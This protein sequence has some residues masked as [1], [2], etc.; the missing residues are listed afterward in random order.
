MTNPHE[1]GLEKFIAESKSESGERRDDLAQAVL[2]AHDYVQG[3]YFVSHPNFDLGICGSVND[4]ILMGLANSILKR[5]L[6]VKGNPGLGK[7]TTAQ[8][9][10]S[11]SYRLP[12]EF[13]EE[14][15]LQGTP[16][17]TE[18]KI[19]GRFDFSKLSEEERVIFS[20]FSQTP[21]TKIV[22]E[23]NRIP[24]QTQNAL[25][26]AVET[27]QFGYMDH[28]VRSDIG[29]H[30]FFATANYSDLGNTEMSPPF[31]D[32]FDVSVEVQQ[33]LWLG[34][35][36]MGE[37]NLA[38]LMDKQR[39]SL[40]EI[41]GAMVR[42]IEANPERAKKIEAE[43]R[44]YAF[45]IVG[46]Q[47]IEEQKAR[48]SNRNLANRITDIFM[49][50]KTDYRTKIDEVA[51][52]QSEF[53]EQISGIS[54][55]GQ[56]SEALRILAK[57]NMFNPNAQVY[58]NSFM[59]HINCIP[60]MD[61]SGPTNH[62]S[63]YPVG[64][65]QNELSVRLRTRGREFAGLISYLKGEDSISV[66]TIGQ[67]LPYLIAHRAIFSDEVEADTSDLS[68]SL[69]MRNA[70]RVVKSF[71][72]SVYGPHKDDLERLYGSLGNPA[73]FVD[74]YADHTEPS[75]REFVRRFQNS[76]GVESGED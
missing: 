48:I 17:L 54:I 61:G 35:Y 30:P 50:K 12:I 34:S 25:L 26:K 52:S 67:V 69:S 49:D 60:K 66:E 19:F 33:P 20:L 41:N 37:P 76:S 4:V 65:V 31:L 11:I 57:S 70:R 73:E 71:G 45:D 10:S 75:I 16:F 23:I 15:M 8:A 42:Q 51:K 36:L 5:N 18:E 39:K 2:N 9:V 74:K 59:D 32:R 63:S 3:S 13:T 38:G 72:E 68:N 43:A 55:D 22:D 53:G 14:C 28:V 29:K 58:W 46:G 47:R 56:T 1:S 6:L 21:S 64:Q 40:L 62:D 27:G 7:T 44:K 24:P